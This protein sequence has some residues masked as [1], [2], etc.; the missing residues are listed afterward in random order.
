M[1]QRD[2]EKEGNREREKLS[3]HFREID[4]QKIDLFFIFTFVLN[5][6]NSIDNNKNNHI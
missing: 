2:E 3:N 5:F 6:F 1:K 4:D